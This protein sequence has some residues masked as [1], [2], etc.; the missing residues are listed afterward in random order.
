MNTKLPPEVTPA[1]VTFSPKIEAR[2]H[3]AA[4]AHDGQLVGLDLRLYRRLDS[5]LAHDVFAATGA[6]FR[7]PL[8]ALRPLIAMLQAQADRIG[9]P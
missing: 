3:P 8:A 9:A 4:S 2:S 7:I 1:A 6:G 5:P